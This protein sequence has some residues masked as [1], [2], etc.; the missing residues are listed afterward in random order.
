MSYKLARL[1]Q[2]LGLIIVPVAVAGNLSELAGS[3]YQLTLG[4]SLL[5]SGVG[6]ILFYAG[7][8]LQQKARPG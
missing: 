5:L 8:T 7:W 3:K 6:V 1:L 2:L 4:E